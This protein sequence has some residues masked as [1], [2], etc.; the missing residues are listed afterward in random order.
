M[1]RRYLAK[2]VIRV[3][4]ILILPLYLNVAFDVPMSFQYTCLVFSWG[5][6][7]YVDLS[8]QFPYYFPTYF[9]FITIGLAI[10]V[11]IP[12]IIFTSWLAQQPREKA[13]KKMALAAAV[14]ISL[15]VYPL[16]ILLPYGGPYM[17]IMPIPG[18][19]MIQLIVP[20]VIA[21]FVVL[22][23]M[24]RQ[25]SYIDSDKRAAYFSQ[26]PEELIHVGGIRPGKFSILSQI[27]GTIALC[28][29]SFA[30]TYG[31]FDPY[32]GGTTFVLM[33][34][35]WVGNYYNYGTGYSGLYLSVAPS[36][37]MILTYAM[38]FFTLAFAYSILQYI[39]TYV[40]KTRVAGY[41]ALSMVVPYAIFLFMAPF[42]LIVPVPVLIVLGFL[43]LFLQ[44]QIP[45]RQTIWED[46]AVQMWYE[47]GQEITVMGNQPSGR[48]A[49]RSERYT[50]VKVPFTYLI[51]SKLRSLRS[52]RIKSSPEMKTNRESDPHK[53]DWAESGDLWAKGEGE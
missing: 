4:A 24:G 39:Q 7:P 36:Y 47:K 21:V 49:M 40:Q 17:P 42:M 25:G 20:W 43:V 29:P 5:M 33:T 23:V 27:L 12:G 41:A 30:Y 1:N 11:C 19:S 14:F 52:S 32:G 31:Y 15:I 13:I 2:T 35:I 3:V 8:M 34:P 28:F 9:N 26:T 10:A 51:I 46:K 44:K 37:A 50:T 38:S 45:P 48:Q 22:P 18:G 16:S 6:F 53:A